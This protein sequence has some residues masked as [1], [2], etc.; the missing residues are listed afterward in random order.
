[1]IT[2]IKKSDHLHVA[3]AVDPACEIAKG[4]I[5]VDLHDNNS[6]A[7]QAAYEC[8]V[9]MLLSGTSTLDRTQ[10]LHKMNSLGSRIDIKINAG[11][12]TI[13]IASSA[14]NWNKTVTLLEQIINDSV[15]S[16]KELKR[17]STQVINELHDAKDDAKTIA[18][19]Q[20]VNSMYATTDPRTVADIDDIAQRVAKTTTA[21]L[22]ELHSRLYKCPW[23][24]SVIGNEQVCEKFATFTQ[25]QT[26]HSTSTDVHHTSTTKSSRRSLL[27]ADV[28]GRQNIDISIGTPLPLK[29][30]DED[31]PSVLFAV[32]VLAKWGGFAGR[33]MSTVRE[34]EGLTY[35]IYGR[36]CGYNQHQTGYLRIMTFFSPEQ[37]EQ[38]LRSTFREINTIYA[39]GITKKEF[40]SFQTILE[41]SRVLQND[42]PLTQLS[43]LHGFN[44]LGFSTED[45]TAYQTSFSDLSVATV[46]QAIKKYLHPSQFT[47]SAAGPIKPHKKQLQ[48]LAQE[49]IDV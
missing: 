31:Y 30:G 45:I 25:K 36:I 29:P 11:L 49:I 18:H 48:A 22:K 3:T 47:I 28:P 13:E 41:T 6:V 44:I 42:S 32:A 21:E 4:I 33:L 39:S 38:G 26:K 46:N 15:F 10:L 43:V 27:L 1:M 20:L 7:D 17:V 35:G 19:H 23:I 5:S 2:T 16:A 34:K 40:N 8:Y 14:T 24:V 37:L 9:E 12:L